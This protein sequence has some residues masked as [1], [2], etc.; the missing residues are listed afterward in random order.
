VDK[1]AAN[2]AMLMVNATLTIP[3]HSSTAPSGKRACEARSRHRIVPVTA[4]CLPRNGENG[5]SQERLRPEVNLLTEF[6]LVVAGAFVLGL[7]M[8][9]AIIWICS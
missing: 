2:I 9:L 6:S 7:P 1:S 3:A 4:F 8:A 5:M